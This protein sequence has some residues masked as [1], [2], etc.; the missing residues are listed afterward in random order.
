MGWDRV[1]LEATGN[2]SLVAELRAGD[3]RTKTYIADPDEVGEMYDWL[4]TNIARINAMFEDRAE[5]RLIADP[6][7]PKAVS[8]LTDQVPEKIREALL[9][10]MT[11]NPQPDPAPLLTMAELDRFPWE[12]VRPGGSEPPN[13][14][15]KM[16]GQFFSMGRYD[17]NNPGAAVE[18]SSAL[19]VAPSKQTQGSN[20]C[21]VAG[22]TFKRHLETVERQFAPHHCELL[23]C[24][25]A[26]HDKVL[27]A[28]PI[29]PDRVIHYMGHHFFNKGDLQRSSLQLANGDGLTPHD[30]SKKVGSGGAR[31]P[32]V[33]IHACR[34]L[35][36]GGVEDWE[37]HGWGPTLRG[38]G[39]RAVIAPYWRVESDD[40]GGVSRAFY[41]LV[42]SGEI[43]IGE[44]LRRVRSENLHPTYLAYALYGDPSMTLKLIGGHSNVGPTP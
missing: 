43:S 3:G 26:T 1:R 30:V 40:I 23:D 34:V 2:H 7:Y 21:L 25:E 12:L 20:H 28:L 33:F 9:E 31:W 39:A 5:S 42:A 17:G 32:L 29:N 44:A 6:P 36:A 13:A 16:L 15:A 4:R 14:G 35:G 38:S 37:P 10:V 11:Q 24:V 19:V 41:P 8:E 18:A 27:D 22:G